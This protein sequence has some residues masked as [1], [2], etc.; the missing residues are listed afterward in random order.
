LGLTLWRGIPET[1]A[2]QP[3]LV[4]HSKHFSLQNALSIGVDQMQRNFAGR[5]G[6]VGA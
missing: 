5:R 2:F 1:S 3:V 6:Q 4:K